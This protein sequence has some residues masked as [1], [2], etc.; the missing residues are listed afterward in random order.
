MAFLSF[1]FSLISDLHGMDLDADPN[2]RPRAFK[3]FRKRW[4]SSQPSVPSE[5]GPLSEQHDADEQ[6]ASD[7]PLFGMD[8]LGSTEFFSLEDPDEVEPQLGP[9]LET[10]ESEVQQTLDGST[11]SQGNPQSCLHVLDPNKREL[12]CHELKRAKQDIGK[13]PWELEG[14]AFLGADRWQGTALASFDS[15]FA[16]SV[17]GASDVCE[18]QVVQTRPA[19]VLSETVL[20]VIPLTLRRARKEGTCG[21]RHQITGSAEV[22]RH[23]TAGSSGYSTWYKFEGTIASGV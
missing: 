4:Q 20:P 22:Q 19:T 9:Q 18:S 13:L 16:S 5:S 11:Q 3:G 8:A 12:S 6:Y 2:M 7:L 23:H 17:V 14:S 21:R 15:L 1:G 10:A